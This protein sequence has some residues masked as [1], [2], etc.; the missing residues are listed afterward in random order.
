VKALTA[1]FRLRRPVPG[2]EDRAPFGVRFA[3]LRDGRTDELATALVVA[4]AEDGNRRVGLESMPLGGR[5]DA[6]VAGLHE[7]ATRYLCR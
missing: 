3:H 4:L 7:A 2:R 5:Y 1:P 6:A